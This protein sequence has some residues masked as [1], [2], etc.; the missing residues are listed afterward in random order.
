MSALEASSAA[1]VV[2]GFDDAV[3]RSAANATDADAR[4]IAAFQR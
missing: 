4:R 1:G 3:R 2:G